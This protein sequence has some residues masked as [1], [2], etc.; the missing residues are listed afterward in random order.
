MVGFSLIYSRI[1]SWFCVEMIFFFLLFLPVGYS[2][3]QKALD[4]YL[5]NYTSGGECLRGY[6]MVLEVLPQSVEGTYR[7]S[8]A[9]MY[10]VFSNIVYHNIL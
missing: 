7:T 3:G 4:G 2:P 10:N 5:A 1:Y 9:Q 6:K 8:D